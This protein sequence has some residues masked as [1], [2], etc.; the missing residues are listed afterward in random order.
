MLNMADE[1]ELHRS[2]I[3]RLY[4]LENKSLSDVMRY[5]KENRG[6]QKGYVPNARLCKVTCAN[7]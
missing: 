6:F 7:K 4:V 1:W 5:V 3:Y 2:T